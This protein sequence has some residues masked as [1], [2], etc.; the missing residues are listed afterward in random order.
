MSMQEWLE[1][2][3]RLTLVGDACLVSAAA[4]GVVIGTE[5]LI[6]GHAEPPAW[7]AVP[8]SLLTLGSVL[9]GPGLAWLLRGRR[10][11]WWGVL[12][13][14]VASLAV[15]LGT[16][17]LVFAAMGLA[18]LLTPITSAEMAGP[19]ALLALGSLGFLAICSLPALG[20]AGALSSGVHDRMGRRLLALR[21]TGLCLLVAFATAAAVFVATSSDP[22]RAEVYVFAILGGFT[23][24]A[25]ALGLDL[26][27]AW[28]RRA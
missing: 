14:F 26:A 12:G 10:L 7:I 18:W 27:R 19:I 16:Q 15:V 4:F 21:L 22:E 28:H 2:H 6:I 17:A 1:R 20:I 13:A 3:P 8:A 25:M 24:A 5:G 11:T 9:V 23:G